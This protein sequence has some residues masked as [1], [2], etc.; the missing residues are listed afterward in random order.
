MM[1]SMAA[2]LIV[3]ANWF[4]LASYSVKLDTHCCISGWLV[5]SC[6]RPNHANSNNHYHYTLSG[7]FSPVEVSS[8]VAATVMVVLSIPFSPATLSANT[9]LLSLLSCRLITQSGISCCSSIP[10]HCSLVNGNPSSTHPPSL[11]TQ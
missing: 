10:A 3:A 4:Q 11:S 9:R 8:P 7:R 1:G 2:P 6:N 5:M